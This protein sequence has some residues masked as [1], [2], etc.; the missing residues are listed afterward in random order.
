VTQADLAA[1]LAEEGFFYEFHPWRDGF[2]QTLL[3]GVQ[4]IE[5]LFYRLEN[6]PALRD[7]VNEFYAQEYRPGLP[8]TY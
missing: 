1:R 6:D 2:P 7:A 4:D 8:R 5:A 3:I